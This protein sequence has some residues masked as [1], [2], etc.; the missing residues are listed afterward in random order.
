MDHLIDLAHA[1]YV[2]DM[3]TDAWHE[4]QAHVREAYVKKATRVLVELAKVGIEL[5]TH[6]QVL[7]SVEA[8]GPEVL[9]EPQAAEEESE[10]E[11]WTH[12][13]RRSRRSRE[14]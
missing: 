14:E 2:A 8:S 13:S 4:E 12:A 9:V 3:P 7:Q 6:V 5:T 11:P 1:L 10:S